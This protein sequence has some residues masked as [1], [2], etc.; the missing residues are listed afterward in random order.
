MRW[1]AGWLASPAGLAVD[2]DVDVRCRRRCQGPPRIPA[3]ADATGSASPRLSSVPARSGGQVRAGWTSRCGV[4]RQARKDDDG[5]TDDAQAGAL[6]DGEEARRDAGGRGTGAFRYLIQLSLLVRAV[7]AAAISSPAQELDL[8]GTRLYPFFAERRTGGGGDDDDDDV[9]GHAWS[10]HDDDVAWH[11]PADGVDNT[12]TSTHARP[13]GQRHGEGERAERGG[14][15][16]RQPG[17]PCPGTPHGQAG[18]AS[19]KK[20]VGGGGPSEEQ[21]S[22]AAPLSRRPRRT[23]RLGSRPSLICLRHPG[24]SGPACQASLNGWLAGWLVVPRLQPAAASALGQSSGSRPPSRRPL[25]P[26]GGLSPS[27]SPRS[28]PLLTLSLL[29][30]RPSLRRLAPCNTGD[31]ADN[32]KGDDQDDILLGSRID[33]GLGTR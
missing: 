19:G 15:R 13:D 26:P 12:Y 31:D 9:E 17:Q 29:V 32:D 14:E 2:V 24:Q 27:L 21:R 20:N 23:S 11:G 33:P 4:E 7:L 22:V 1:L 16:E 8:A 6:V 3:Y 18:L 10:G 25:P 5:W 28:L 30:L